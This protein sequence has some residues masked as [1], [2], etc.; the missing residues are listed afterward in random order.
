MVL[1]L[2]SI[3][4][5]RWLILAYLLVIGFAGAYLYTDKQFSEYKLS[6]AIE[7]SERK[8]KVIAH[9]EGVIDLQTAVAEAKHEVEVKYESRISKLYADIRNANATIG[10]L[11]QTNNQARNYVTT[12]TDC[13]AISEYTTTY[14]DIYE[15]LGKFAEA[16]SIEADRA[17]A[18]A[19][20][21]HEASRVQVE[22]YNKFIKE[23]KGEL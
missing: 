15:E 23:Q 20:R 4:P 8:D 7:E 22:E 17:T 5:Y 10:S 13:P 21:Q 1:F 18:E 9:Q 14:I 16:T 11:S 2:K 12:S 19:V 6:I 3:W